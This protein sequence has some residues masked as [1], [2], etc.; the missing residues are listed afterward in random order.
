MMQQQQMQYGAPMQTQQY[1]APM[2]QQYA[3]PMQ[4]QYMPQVQQQ[5]VYQAPAQTQMMAPQQ[6]MAA[7][8]Q[9]HQ[10][11]IQQA[12]PQARGATYAQNPE[13]AEMLQVTVFGT[14]QLNGAQSPSVDIEI[15]GKPHKHTLQTEAITGPQMTPKS[16]VTYYLPGE[17]LNFTVSEQG[18]TL[19][20]VQISGQDF[21]PN[22][23]EGDLPLMDPAT[24][25]QGSG[26]L[27]VKI[28][29]LGTSG[30]MA[31]LEPVIVQQEPKAG[32]MVEAAPFVHGT[33]GARHVSPEEYQQLANNGA[34]LMDPTEAPANFAPQFMPQQQA[35]PT[36]QQP[37]PVQA[38]LGQVFQHPG[39]MQQQYAQPQQQ[40]FAQPQQ[41]PMYGQQQPQRFAQ[42]PM[43]GQPMGQPMYR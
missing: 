7:P 26:Y 19:G 33:S 36:Y 38:S 20:D 27:M 28:V 32:P 5:Q 3:A 35:Q 37:A 41:Q 18:M 13:G 6:M 8:Q 10:A 40:A 24:G 43:M 29:P 23:L 31:E 39:Q 2:Q 11:P 22:G 9:F 16:L 21:H 15:A 4:T 17:H 30:V 25:S 12:P 1:G 14:K 34:Q 42:Q